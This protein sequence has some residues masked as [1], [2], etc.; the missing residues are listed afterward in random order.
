L[1]HSNK[2]HNSSEPL[3][4][5]HRVESDSNFKGRLQIKNK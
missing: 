4:V 5:I 3:I 1:M 2:S